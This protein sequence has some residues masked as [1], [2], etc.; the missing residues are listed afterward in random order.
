MRGLS[1]VVSEERDGDLFCPYTAAFF[2]INFRRGAA[3][4]GIR[5]RCRISNG[6]VGTEFCLFAIPVAT[7]APQYGRYAVEIS[8]CP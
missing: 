5:D 3:D 1:L 7:P 6:A 8:H 2:F 4:S